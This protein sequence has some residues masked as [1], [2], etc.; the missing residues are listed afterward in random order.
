MDCGLNLEKLRGSL[1]N[2]TG[3]TGIFES[4]R[5]DLDR[6]ALVWWD[7]DLIRAV[8]LRFDGPD[9]ICVRAAAELAGETFP[10]AA[11]LGSSPEMLNLVL[12]G[13]IRAGFGLGWSMRHA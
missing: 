12:W 5:L 2:V 6:V 3:R 1:E 10:A 11:R 9:Q 7:P 8:Y 13:S 4:G